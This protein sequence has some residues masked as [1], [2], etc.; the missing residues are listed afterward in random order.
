MLLTGFILSLSKVAKALKL[1]NFLFQ[2]TEKQRALRKSIAREVSDQCL[3]RE[4]TEDEKR[5]MD[6]LI[7]TV[8]S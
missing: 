8:F 7:E 1:T 4:K 2:N 5:T 3:V 6:R